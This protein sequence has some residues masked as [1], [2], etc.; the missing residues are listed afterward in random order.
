MPHDRSFDILIIGAG[1]AGIAAAVRAS[2]EGRSVGVV[3]DNFEVGGQIWRGEEAGPTDAGA[4]LWLRKF[5][6]ASPGRTTGTRILGRSAHNSLLAGRDGRVAELG[7]GRPIR[8]I[9]S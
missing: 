9:A 4:A 8:A 2:G 5:R 3:A 1:P 7:Y 6:E